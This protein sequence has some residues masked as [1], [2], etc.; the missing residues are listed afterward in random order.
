LLQIEE[1]AIGELHDLY[2][3]HNPDEYITIEREHSKR[4]SSTS[5]MANSLAWCH[6]GV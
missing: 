1:Q 5:S 2:H 3:V 6:D 4:A